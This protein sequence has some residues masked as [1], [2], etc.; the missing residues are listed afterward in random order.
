MV[1]DEP[2][3]RCAASRFDPHRITTKDATKLFDF[4]HD[5][6][7]IAGRDHAILIE[8]LFNESGYGGS[9]HEPR[10]VVAD[11][12]NRLT[13]PLGGSDITG[14]EYSRRVLNILGW[15]DGV[16]SDVL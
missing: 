6:G 12:Q 4:L 8:G 11:F 13:R 3:I 7:A 16:R 5:G 15:I 14:V 2:I 1:S 10:N 9:S